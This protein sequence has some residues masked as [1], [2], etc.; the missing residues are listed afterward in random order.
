MVT[1]GMAEGFPLLMLSILNLIFSI[2]A[3]CGLENCTTDVMGSVLGPNMLQDL[4][5]NVDYGNTTFTARFADALQTHGCSVQPFTDDGW[6]SSKGPPKLNL[7]SAWHRDTGEVV[8]LF[9]VTI[10]CTLSSYNKSNK[11]R[12]TPH[13]QIGISLCCGLVRFD[14]LYWL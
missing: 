1:E 13:A 6:F 12:A 2:P 5:S 3:H 8:S 9:G 7:A 10:H 14:V 4:Q 11:C